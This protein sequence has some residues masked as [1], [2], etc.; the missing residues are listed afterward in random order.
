MKR[1]FRLEIKCCLEDAARE[2]IEGS[3][4]ANRPWT[5]AIKRN[6]TKLGKSHN[7]QVCCSGLQMNGID[8]PNWGEWLYD[9]CWLKSVQNDDHCYESMPLALE[10]EWSM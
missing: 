4:A 1:D 2:M 10:S 7:F 9:L 3:N 6:L 8:S 5:N